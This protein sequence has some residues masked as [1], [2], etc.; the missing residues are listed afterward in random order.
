[1]K[2]YKTVDFKQNQLQN[3]VIHNVD[4]LPDVV[5]S[6]PGQLVYLN[7]SPIGVLH[8]FDGIEWKS[9]GGSSDTNGFVFISDITAQN[10]SNN[11]GSRTWQTG[12][13]NEVLETCVS[14]TTLV[15]VEFIASTN[16]LTYKPQLLI[17]G[18]SVPEINIIANV[19]RPIFT[20]TFD[21]ELTVTDG[22]GDYPIAISSNGGATH[23]AIVQSDPAPV[24][25]TAVFTGSYP[26]TQT[27]LAAGNSFGFSITT[28][29]D[30][31]L[32][33]FDN[34]SSYAT[35]QSN[36]STAATSNWSGT[37]NIAD[38]GNTANQ[39]PARVRVRKPTGTWSAWVTTNSAGNT[40]MVHVVTLN[41]VAP[42]VT[43]GTITYPTGTYAQQALKGSE[44][45]TV[46]NTVLNQGTNPTYT[47]S[48][49]N[50]QLSITSP[51]T[52]QSPKTVQRIAGEYNI[53]T[54]NLRLT[55]LRQENG[56]STT[57][58]TVVWIA[59]STFM[60]IITP[61]ARLRSGGNDGTTI[62]NHTITMRASSS[63][64]NSLTTPQRLLQ[65][66]TI[67]ALGTGEGLWSG[68][69]SF[70]TAATQFTRTMQVHDNDT[71]GTFNFTGLTAV[72]L[73][74]IEII[75]FS[76]GSS[77]TLGGF[78]SRVLTVPA[79]SSAGTQPTPWEIKMNV[80]ATQFG[81]DNNKLIATWSWGNWP[82]SPT[83]YAFGTTT[84]PSSNYGWSIEAEGRDPASVGS[85]GLRILH[86]DA[87]NVVSDPTTLTVEE[88]V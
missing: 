45:A 72:N 47:Y 11:V 33:E 28:D 70:G 16:N 3:P 42:T 46:V 43:F 78:V 64:S 14:D 66:P 69:W 5:D 50:G 40:D 65:A 77:Y 18:L 9:G 83:L 29:I 38:R 88:I 82:A 10:V 63:A 71:K 39:Y 48:S 20:G 21:I 22:N 24:I 12:A 13:T 36:I 31:D 1:M 54:N 80:A 6:I 84:M 87:V 44:T 52:L 60:H 55:V 27:E 7:E 75:S 53:G 86:P 34:T 61:A 81:F 56:R 25:Q 8:F 32:I 62:Q 67:D 41:N 74:G 68:P 79:F 35:N 26:G 57:A 51:T 49:P 37:V 2:I 17:N 76:T 73:A 59:N 23:Q 19:D 58:N 4:I 30:F 15:T 85:T